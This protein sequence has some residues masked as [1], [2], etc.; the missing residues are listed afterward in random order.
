VRWLIWIIV[1]VI[2]AD[3]LLRLTV[4]KDDTR[5][6]FVKSDKSGSRTLLVYL[7]GILA[8][9]KQSSLLMV[10][11]WKQYGDVLLVSYDGKRFKP[12]NI[13]RD[14]DRWVA[15]RG[16]RYR[17]VVFIGSSLGGLLAYDTAPKLEEDGLRVKYALVAA[18]TGY[19]D[20]K[21]AG[22]LSPFMYLWWGGPIS[23][24]TTGKL[25]LKGLFQEP[26][27]DNIE[28]EVDR[29]ELKQR[30][31]EA[32]ASPFSVYGDQIRYVLGHGKPASSTLTG[33]EGVYIR[34][35]RDELVAD[36]A[37]DSWK[38]AFGGS[39]PLIESDTTH[40]GYNEMPTTFAGDFERALES[41]GLS[42]G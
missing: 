34:C 25:F 26:K 27:D 36:K 19:G 24:A 38:S 4:L 28:P 30:V 10:D 20:L 39:L 37:Y 8:D 7:P 15:I 18:P 2:M 41:L 21:G 31:E 14:I 29:D 42:K 1:A 40:V 12:D 16:D 5:F 3:A 33:V 6:D 22:R 32:K 13:T 11:T 35:G 23:N 9:G 17:E